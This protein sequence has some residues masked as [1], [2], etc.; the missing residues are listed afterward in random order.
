MDLGRCDERTDQLLAGHGLHSVPLCHSGEL[1]F[2]LGIRRD[3]E[4]GLPLVIVYGLKQVG[5][6]LDVPQD[7]AEA[8]KKAGVTLPRSPV[9]ASRAHVH[10]DHIQ[11]GDT[12]PSLVRPPPCGPH[13][14]PQYSRVGAR[15][16]W[17]HS[18]A[19]WTSSAM[20]VCTWWTRRDTARGILTSSRALRTEPGCTWRG[21]AHTTGGSLTGSH[22][23]RTGSWGAHMAT[24]QRLRRR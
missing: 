5:F 14:V 19:P 1:V 9:Y 16:R 12:A 3:W 21:T 7:A 6:V 15:R 10:V 13:E 17:A 2:D 22:R 24:R 11:V 20:A 8:L 18:L 23:L 4:K